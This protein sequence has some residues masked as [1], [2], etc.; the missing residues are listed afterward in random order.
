MRAMTT[1]TRFKDFGAAP[2]EDATT[3]PL[4]F[5]LYGETFNCLPNIQGKLLLDLV[6][7]SSSEDAG[8]TAA[9]VL[10]FFRQVLDEE[11]YARFEILVDSK[12]KNV[13]V[14]KLSEIIGWLMQEYT[15]RP[16]GQPEAS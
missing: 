4:S 1:T 8:K 16:E 11:S 7:D 9:I 2:E 5:A 6:A 3:E 12:D 15:N 14:N 13:S 10:K